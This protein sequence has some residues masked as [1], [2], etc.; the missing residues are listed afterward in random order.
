MGRLSHPEPTVNNALKAK[1]IRSRSSRHS[2]SAIS[3]PCSA[4]GPRSVECVIVFGVMLTFAY[5]VPQQAGRSS[6]TP[7]RRPAPRPAS[8][9]GRSEVRKP[10]RHR[11]PHLRHP[12][13]RLCH[14]HDQVARCHLVLVHLGSSVPGCPGLRLC[15]PLGI[16]TLILLSRYEPMKTLSPHHRAARS[17]QARLCVHHAEHLSLFRRVPHHLVRQCARRN[18]LVPEPHPRRLVDHLHPRLHLPLANPVH[19]S[20]LARSQAQ[21]AEP[22]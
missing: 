11:H 15:S 18:S 17:R 21:Q 7:I 12:H 6:A 4:P 9:G 3:T 16:L 14:R 22:A 20:P 10:L 8:T 13:D 1:G 19:A 2:A 5:H